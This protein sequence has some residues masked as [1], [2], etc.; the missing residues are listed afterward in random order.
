MKFGRTAP[1][2]TAEIADEF[3]QLVEEGKAL[4]GE[5]VKRPIPKA[6]KNI[7]LGCFEFDYMSRSHTDLDSELEA[8]AYSLAPISCP[9]LPTGEIFLL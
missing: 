9:L 5:F 3:G 8:S 7:F 1:R 2:S 4:L 6:V